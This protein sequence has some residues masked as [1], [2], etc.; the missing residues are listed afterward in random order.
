VET[1]PE[2]EGVPDLS[3]TF[4]AYPD[5]GLSESPTGGLIASTDKLGGAITER[6]G[7]PG[8]VDKTAFFTEIEKQVPAPVFKQIGDTYVLPDS[9]ILDQELINNWES[10]YDRSWSDVTTVLD[11]L[12]DIDKDGPKTRPR[13][14][15]QALTRL[16]VKNAVVKQKSVE[17]KL[18]P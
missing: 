17:L 8:S 15:D 10:T 9:P 18:N 4:Y 11:Y 5:I 2:V 14:V 7:V 3:E 16:N 12:R 13:L 1:V 6:T